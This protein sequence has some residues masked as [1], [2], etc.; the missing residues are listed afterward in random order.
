MAYDRLLERLYMVDDG[1]IVKCAT[2]LLARDL[3][4]RATIDIDVY[5]AQETEIA[6]AD[7]RAAAGRDLGR[8]HYGQVIGRACRSRVPGP[9][10]GRAAPR[11]ATGRRVN[12]TRSPATAC[13]QVS[14][15]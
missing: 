7:F 9:D 5:R 6:E 4:M 1:W 10:P 13:Y 12:L 15:G 8:R 3:G 14:G 2:A 11:A